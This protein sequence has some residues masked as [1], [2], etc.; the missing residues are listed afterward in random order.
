MNKIKKRQLPNVTLI[1]VTSINI[2]ETVRALLYSM[3]GIEFGEAVL[4]THKKPFYLPKSIHYKHTQRLKN[5]DDFSYLMVYGLGEYVDTDYALIVHYDG[6]VV[7]PENW[8]EDFLNYDYIG[9]PWRLPRED[10]EDRYRDINGNICRVGNGVSLRSKRLMKLPKELN[11]EWK[12][13]DSGLFNEDCFICCENKHIFEQ[14]GMRIA[15]IEVAKYFGHEQMIPEIE[16]IEPFLFHQ[17]RGR[18]KKYPRFKSIYG[19]F[20]RGMKRIW[21]RKY[22][23]GK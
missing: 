12:K 22:T 10:E 14:A 21:R 19:I 3:K 20:T 8:K 18:N 5:I 6:F 15:P 17:W 13:M 2:Y 7:H 16:G 9:S 1:A 11:M 4:V 23:C